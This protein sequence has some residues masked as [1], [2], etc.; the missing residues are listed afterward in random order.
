MSEQIDREVVPM[1]GDTVWAATPVIVG[2]G[3][4]PELGRR[5][6]RWSWPGTVCRMSRFT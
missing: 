3:G 5:Q 6:T 4:G 2:G 1:N